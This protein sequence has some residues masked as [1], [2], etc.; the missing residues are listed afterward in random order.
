M[1]DTEPRSDTLQHQM[2]R[3]FGRL[4]TFWYRMTGGL[5]GAW[6]GGPA[7]LLT[8]TGRRSGKPRTLPLLYLETG[9]GYALV[10]SFAGADHHPA[11]YLNLVA[12]PE[13]EIQV[14]ARRLRARAQTADPE[15][16]AELWPRL[17]ELYGGYATYQERTARA[18]PV[19][20][21]LPED[22]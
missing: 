6:A 11:W 1:P 17:L 3:S 16:R 21:L 12:N 2:I 10:A 14:G 15:R 4:H 18:I 5:I 22:G 9:R 7:L 8:T 20:E 19:V 13:V